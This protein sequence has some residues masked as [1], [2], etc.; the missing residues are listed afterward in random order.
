MRLLLDT[1]VLLW[2]LAASSRLTSKARSA[3][4]GSPA[5][6]VSAATAWEI[7]I[8]KRLGK[9]DAP[10]DLEAALESS[11]FQPLPVTIPHAL[12]AGSL[13]LHHEDPFDRMLI[14]QAQAEG[15]T[16]VTRDP[17]MKMYGAPVLF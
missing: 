4:A 11:R 1:H 2:W 10:D 3:I 16:L 8:K 17:R 12:A 5:V 14:A 9:L 7:S 15:L 6:Y 13:A